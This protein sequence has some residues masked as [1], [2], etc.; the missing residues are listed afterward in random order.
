MKG[1]LSVSDFSAV[2]FNTTKT[3]KEKIE[4]IQFCESPPVAPFGTS[5]QQ[6]R[7]T[8]TLGQNW[9]YWN[10]VVFPVTDGSVSTGLKKKIINIFSAA[11]QSA[12]SLTFGPSWRDDTSTRLF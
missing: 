1:H 5:P 6:N 10:I 2:F 9:D 12:R 8:S 7:T 4:D 11:T 3:K